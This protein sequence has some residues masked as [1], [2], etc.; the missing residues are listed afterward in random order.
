VTDDLSAVSLTGLQMRRDPGGGRLPDD[1]TSRTVAG[2][3]VIS[4]LGDYAY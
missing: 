1:R 2:G 4:V 3:E